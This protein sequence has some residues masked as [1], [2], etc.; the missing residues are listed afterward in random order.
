M[1]ARGGAFIGLRPVTSEFSRTQGAG[2]TL[3]GLS[4]LSLP[5]LERRWRGRLAKGLSASHS[6]MVPK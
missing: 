4:G 6:R 5:R 1:R 3:G 2:P